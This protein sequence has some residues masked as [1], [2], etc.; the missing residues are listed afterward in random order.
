MFTCSFSSERSEFRLLLQ[1]VRA[2]V[3]L[4]QT[5]FPLKGHRNICRAPVCK[6]CICRAPNLTFLFI[7]TFLGN[8]NQYNN[9]IKF[10]QLLQNY[11]QTRSNY[12]SNTVDETETT[13]NNIVN[14]PNTAV[15]TDSLSYDSSSNSI[16]AADPGHQNAARVSARDEIVNIELPDHL[17][18]GHKQL[19]EREQKSQREAETAQHTMSLL[20]K[21]SIS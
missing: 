7:L 9:Q 6:L 10:L 21:V 15:S 20:K 1:T 13:R 2:R 17:T 12:P 18:P 5:C 19:S 11:I 16:M 14:P 4:T 8:R 3:Q